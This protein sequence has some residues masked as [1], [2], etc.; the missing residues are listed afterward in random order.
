MAPEGKKNTERDDAVMSRHKNI[1]LR[2]FEAFS[3][4][5]SIKSTRK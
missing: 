2:Q 3:A 4:R 5:E 1:S